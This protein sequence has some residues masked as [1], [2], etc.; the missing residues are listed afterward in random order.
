MIEGM[1]GAIFVLSSFVGGY[2]FRGRQ[3]KVQPV[4][5]L[6]QEQQFSPE[7]EAQMANIWNAW[8]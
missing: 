2:F 7:V 5:E 3:E 4:Q 8:K 6:K 1:I